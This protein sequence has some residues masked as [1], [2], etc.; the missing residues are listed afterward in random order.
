MRQCRHRA[1]EAAVIVDLETRR[2]LDRIDAEDVAGRA[3]QPDVAKI[4]GLV[5]KILVVKKQADAVGRV[6]SLRLDL[7]MGEEGDFGIGAAE[8]RNDLVAHGAGEIA[9]MEFLELDG[10]GVP[11]HGVAERT[12][13]ELDQHLAAR[14]GIVVDEQSLPVL[15]DLDAES[16][17]VTLGA[18]D[19]SRLDLGLEQDFAGAFTR[20]TGA[21]ASA[22]LRTLLKHCVSWEDRQI[23]DE[24][25]RAPRVNVSS[26][27]PPRGPQLIAGSQGRGQP[28]TT[29][30]VLAIGVPG[31][32]SAG[33]W[34]QVREEN[35]V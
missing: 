3:V 2:D 35:G 4:A 17:E 8:Q 15:P 13:R 6:I 32:N 20:E 33:R 10:I 1:R 26:G 34:R 5:D 12:Y 31:R 21:V 11:T 18:V 25:T 16:Y 23:C 27:A 30:R 9:A 14:G 22:N 19:A 7:L 29:R 24:A 28:G